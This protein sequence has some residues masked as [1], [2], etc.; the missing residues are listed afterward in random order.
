MLCTKMERGSAIRVHITS[1][2]METKK[3]ANKIIVL[4]DD[5]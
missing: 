4:H 1:D 3:S 5:I 2:A